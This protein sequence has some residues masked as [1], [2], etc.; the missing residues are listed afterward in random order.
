MELLQQ[1]AEATAT[2]ASILMIH[3]GL[4]GH[5]SVSHSLSPHVDW[6]LA[7]CPAISTPRLML[8]G[9]PAQSD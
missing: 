7:G 1:P 2:P 4:V 5:V 3:V 9:S 8:L 6:S